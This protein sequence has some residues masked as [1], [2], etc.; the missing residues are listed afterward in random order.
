MPLSFFGHSEPQN[1]FNEKFLIFKEG[2]NFQHIA[3]TGDRIPKKKE[4]E[5]KPASEKKK[6][7]EEKKPPSEKEVA[8]VP[9]QHAKK[10]DDKEVEKVAPRKTTS[11]ALDKT[12]K[13]IQRELFGRDKLGPY[14][15]KIKDSIEKMD[16]DKLRK[17]IQAHNSYSGDFRTWNK[18]LFELFSV[19]LKKGQLARR[20]HA[21]FAA[22]LQIFLADNFKSK[23][24]VFQAKRGKKANPFIYIDGKLGGYTI[25]VLAAYWNNKYPEKKETSGELAY[26]DLSDD[27]RNRKRSKKA[28]DAAIV[29]LKNKLGGKS[30]PAEVLA[31]KDKTKLDNNDL[32]ELRKQLRKNKKQNKAYLVA[33]KKF[34]KENKIT[35]E[36]GEAWPDDKLD[37]FRR[38]YF[39]NLPHDEFQKVAKDAGVLKKETAASTP[40]PTPPKAPKVLKIV[41]LEELPKDQ[42]KGVAQL[43]HNAQNLADKK[44]MDSFGL[45]TL[46]ERKSELVEEVQDF[47]KKRSDKMGANPEGQTDID[48]IDEDYMRP[49]AW[50]RKAYD[51]WVKFYKD[52]AVMDSR[53]MDPDEV[54]AKKKVVDQAFIDYKESLTHYFKKEEEIAANLHE[55]LQQ[56]IL[57]EFEKYSF[58]SDIDASTFIYVNSVRLPNQFRK[59]LERKV[60][61]NLFKP[62]PKKKNTGQLDAKR[63]LETYFIKAPLET[64]K[65][66]DYDTFRASIK[67]EK[68]TELSHLVKRYE[69]RFGSRKIDVIDVFNSLIYLNNIDQFANKLKYYV[70]NSYLSK[71][72]STLDGIDKE[73]FDK[74]LAR[75]RGEQNKTVALAPNE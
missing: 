17:F 51:H 13:R 2:A 75:V 19:K 16:P 45:E 55:E 59:K 54:E 27:F 60:P 63:L 31:A 29:H 53:F 36:I 44:A 18:D 37:E 32:E 57:Q 67:K 47:Y 12:R 3:S 14:I 4:E 62:R 6:Y 11:Q 9:P 23:G 22:A 5:N 72:K 38:G 58:P 64:F 49:S 39:K 24:D 28:F 73:P 10:P 41:K 33:A 52:L 61:Y 66:G 65:A 69:N 71:Y 46:A 40:T 74:M 30:A 8:K 42:Q 7:L 56:N 35:S 26:A 25:S 50:P 68:Q 48:I 34:M 20:E 43:L 1:L 21:R 15:D 70:T